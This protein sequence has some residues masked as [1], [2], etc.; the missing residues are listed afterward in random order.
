MCVIITTRNKLRLKNSTLALAY[1]SNPHGW[2]IMHAED[3]QIFIAKR[4]SDFTDFLCEL[5][6]VPDDSPLAIHFRLATHG[7][8]NDNNCH[9]F[10]VWSNVA[11]MHNGIIRFKNL[12]KLTAELSDSA[13]YA[14]NIRAYLKKAGGKI[15]KIM[16]QIELETYGSKILIMDGDGKTYKTF[17]HLWINVDDGVVASNDTFL[18]K[19][20]YYSSFGFSSFKNEKKKAEDNCYLYSF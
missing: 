11:Y 14:R 2:G 19:Y 15:R 16:K 3:G 9:P 5:K 4:A 6:N 7:K 10:M 1:E 13:I 12:E 18:R 8:V 17:P 20:D